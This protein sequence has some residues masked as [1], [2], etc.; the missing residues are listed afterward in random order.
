MFHIAHFFSS[1]QVFTSVFPACILLDDYQL[2]EPYS[3]DE[4]G[5][6]ELGAKIKAQFLHLRNSILF[7]K[8]IRVL[9]WHLQIGYVHWVPLCCDLHRVPFNLLTFSVTVLNYNSQISEL[10]SYFVV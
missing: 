7:Q 1:S 3:W 6:G 10:C 4:G 8:N 2:C 5:D 9:P